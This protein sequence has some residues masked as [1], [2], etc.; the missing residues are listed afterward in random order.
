V[1]STI[2]TL[3]PD[4]GQPP[5]DWLEPAAARTS[6][7][8]LAAA[9]APDGGGEAVDI[10][11]QAAQAI[12]GVPLGPVGDGGVAAHAAA[13]R[14][15]LAAG[16]NAGAAVVR[17]GWEATREE[18]AARGGLTALLHRLGSE[19]WQRLSSPRPLID[20]VRAHLN[21]KLCAALG[22]AALGLGLVLIN[23][24]GL[25]F[26]HALPSQFADVPVQEAPPA[27]AATGEERPVV[28]VGVEFTRVNIRYCTFQQIRLEALGPLTE[29]AD[30]VVFN[31]LVEDWNARCTR[32]RYRAADKDAVD[33]E[34]AGRRAL[35]EV[36]GRALMNSWRRKIVTTV[37]QRPASA[38]LE[39]GDDTP[40]VRAA[41]L[42]AA[43]P[44]EAAEPLPLLITSGRATP[45]DADR[46][47]GL[48]LRT[49]SLA[50]LR[51]DIATR[52]QRRLNDL[53]YTI[54][55][56]DGTWGTMSRN[57]LRRFKEANGLL[58]ND[59]FDA[60]TV[61][62]LFSTSAITAT[63]AGLRDDG[64][65]TIETAYPPPPAAGM[66]PLNRADGQRIQQRLT[67]LGY[68]NGHG[69]GAWG[70][71]SRNALRTFKVANGLPNDDDWNA[72]AEA[73]LFD[74]QAVHAGDATAGAVRSPVPA[75]IAGVAVP[76]PPRR[77]P[78]PV[79]AAKTA[80]PAAA[81]ARDGPRPPGAIHGAV[82]RAAAAALR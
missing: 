68:Y 74:E 31:A 78:P 2:D 37:Q 56:A 60:E 4:G 59:A 73:V 62:R 35:L 9:R 71:A 77:P 15:L 19:L 24:H 14:R 72:M 17:E 79:A 25:G 13:L 6:K 55:P 27:E 34:A 63:A 69:E 36:E 18:I 22:V 52:V 38:D 81:S 28:G 54:S 12:A 39:T 33:G 43:P 67:E 29:G 48:S 1:S 65:A 45:E 61:T 26:L 8:N 32:Y 40:L 7:H 70:M 30:L 5:P 53:G 66:N 16:I 10:V 11:R 42:A 46:E 23:R 82:T 44:R 49:P 3:E 58:G 51:A 20:A 41:G 75:P 80:E 64:V 21:L 57:A 47:T 50:L 76:L